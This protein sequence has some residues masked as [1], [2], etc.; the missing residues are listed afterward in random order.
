MK[1][2]RNYCY[3]DFEEFAKGLVFGFM[4]GKVV[5]TPD[6]KGVSIEIVVLYD[7]AGIN[8][9]EKFHVK[10]PGADEEYLKSF[11]KKEKVE[12]KDIKKA[13]VYGDYQNAL[14][15]TGRVCKLNQTQK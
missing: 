9:Y 13:V 2:L 7:P 14:S 8:D 1:K 4:G 12:I 5:D 15:V 11:V 3:F 10:V 6:F